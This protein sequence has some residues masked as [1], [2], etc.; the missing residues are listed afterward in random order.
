MQMQKAGNIAVG[1][2]VIGGT[3][4]VSIDSTRQNSISAGGDLILV[5]ESNAAAATNAL[6]KKTN[7]SQSGAFAG[8]SVINY[9]TM[10]NIGGNVNV[11]KVE[12][13]KVSST[14]HGVN[15][16]TVKSVKSEEK[17]SVKETALNTIL[18]IINNSLENIQLTTRLKQ[19][20]SR[21]GF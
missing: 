3:T 5:A 16:T 21:D 7:S 13:Q 18:G 11:T 15:G 17:N 6:G 8:V 20:G 4:K 9:D 14:Q 19:K 2:S 1:V 12:N 10:A